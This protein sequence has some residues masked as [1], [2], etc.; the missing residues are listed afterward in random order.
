MYY[1]KYRAVVKDT[2]DPEKR[3]RIKVMC[4]A[5]LGKQLSNW[6][7]PCFPPN[8]FSVP[9]KDTMVWVEFEGGRKDSPIYVGAFYTTDQRKEIFLQDEYNPKDFIISTQEG[10][11]NVYSKG[12]ILN[13]SFKEIKME[14]QEATSI[15]SDKELNV[16]S[17]ESTNIK[18]TKDVN[19]EPTGNFNT[20]TG[21]NVNLN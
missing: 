8:C 20:K 17:K 16:E 5:V 3:G 9:I 21:G 12:G 6:A 13:K 11:V 4:P 1:G 19:I 14:S 2:N 7:L 18:S 10:W 15:K